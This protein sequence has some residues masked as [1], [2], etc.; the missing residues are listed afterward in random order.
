MKI[1]TLILGISLISSVFTY[2]LDETEQ[3][4][5]CKRARF[6]AGEALKVE[7]YKEAALYYIKGEKICGGYDK[8]NYDRLIG[9]LQYTINQETDETKK[10]AYMDTI[11]FFYDKTEKLGFYDKA[12]SLARA[13]FELQAP[14]QDGEKIDRLL[15]EGIQMAGND[16]HE[17]YIQIY[18]QNIYVMYNNASD[19][20][21]KS[22]L[23]KR[24]ISEYF[25]LSKKVSD[26]KM[27]A[28]TQES[29][30]QFFNDVVRSCDDLLPELKGFMSSLPADLEVKKTTVN[31]FISLMEDKGCEESDE[32]AMLIDT[33][34][35]I[36]PSVG[37]VIA[38]GKLLRAKKDYGASSDAF[39]DAKGMAESDEQKEEL[40]YFILMNTMDQR[41][42][43]GAYTQAMGIS[44]KFRSDALK[45]AARCVF[46]TANNCGTSTF[47]RKCNY[48]LAEELAS[49]GG[50][51]SLAA[52][53]KSM[54][55]TTEEIFDA[56]KKRGDS[57]TLSCWN[58]SVTIQ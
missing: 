1:T 8:A 26:L 38:K 4:R 28:E 15:S 36:D 58:K 49:Q 23:K 51:G 13:V 3:E 9:S 37:A 34:I 35:K 25:T 55:P 31:N 43:K 39:R 24:I 7:N 54:F 2:A 14:E 42:Y 40:D 20:A 29:M 48:Y 32:Y 46:N 12:S 47:D 18:Y 33:L 10:A 11:R 19:E 17:T 50:D 5:E 57:V 6:L 27:S 30:N 21:K 22:S 45:I 44:G 41:N 52:K 56:G 53:C 16:I